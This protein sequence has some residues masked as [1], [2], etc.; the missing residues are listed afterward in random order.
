MKNSVTSYFD[1]SLTTGFFCRVKNRVYLF[2][3]SLLSSL[4]IIA[5]TD[6]DTSWKEIYRG[7]YPK[8]NDLVNT[9]LNAQFDFDKSYL[10]GEVWITL[11][12]HFYPTDS[13]VLDAKQMN[14]TTVALVQRNTIKPLHYGYDGWHLNIKLGR[15]YTASEK[16]IIYIKYTAKPN[17]AKLPEYRRGLYFINPRGDQKDKP[18]QI[19]TDGETENTSVWCPIIDKPDQKTTEEIMMTV[20]DKFVTLSNGQLISQKINADGARTDHWKMDQP[21]SPYLFFMGAG[22]FAIVKDQYKGK[23][24]NYYVEKEYKATARRVFGQTPEMMAYFENITGVPFPWVKYSQIALRDFTSTAMENT[25]ATAH[26]ENAQQDSRELVDGN[27]W[28]NNIAHELFHQWFGDYVG[29]ESWSNLT[30]SESF[31]RYG[32]YLADDQYP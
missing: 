28:E 24:V 9:K 17:E 18:T 10:N 16:Y 4:S 8:I 11:K 6:K 31:A 5:Q 15:L 32:E 3:I 14:I 29:C 20:P 30:L 21:H 7:S 12:P 13:L 1:R 2:V 25:T 22:D 19:W 27:R 23:E 26:A